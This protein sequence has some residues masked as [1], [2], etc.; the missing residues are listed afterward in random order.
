MT[1]SIWEQ[2]TVARLTNLFDHPIDQYMSSMDNICKAA[3]GTEA[4]EVAVVHC[5]HRTVCLVWND[6]PLRDLRCGTILSGYTIHARGS[7]GPETV[8]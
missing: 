1:F 7:Q 8:Q 4:S 6:D 3:T 2:K 5:N